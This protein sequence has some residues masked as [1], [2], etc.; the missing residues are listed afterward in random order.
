MFFARD[1]KLGRPVAIKVLLPD[2]AASLGSERFLREIE[3]AAKLTHPHIVGLHDSGEADGL[4]YYVM[5]FLD[6][7]SLRDR[8]DREK[9]LAIEDALQITRQVAD[10]LG[11]AHSMGIVHRDI[12][13]ENILFKAGHAVVSDFGIARAVAEAG[14]VSLTE[15][16]LAIGTPAYMSPEQ[17]SGEREPDSRTDIYALAC[18][19][20][21]MLAGE[22]PY[23]GPTAQA[24]LA[25]KSVGMVP[26]LRAVRETVPR[27]IELSIVRALAKAPADRF[28]TA[29]K[30]IEALEAFPP[31]EDG[32][33]VSRLPVDAA[34]VKRQEI[35]DQHT[36]L[37]V[38]N[39]GPALTLSRR[40]RVVGGRA[41]P[42]VAVAG[43][44]A[45]AVGGWLGSRVAPAGAEGTLI[46]VLP[47]E[48]IG[49]NEQALLADGMSDEL[50]TRLGRLPGISV[51]SRQSARQ[52]RDSPLSTQEIGRALGATHLLLGSIRWGDLEQSASIRVLP[53]LVD[54]FTD[55]EVWSEQFDMDVRNV[56][57]VQSAIAEA[58]A[59]ELGLVL[60]EAERATLSDRP[61]DDGEAYD[62]YLRGR[63]YEARGFQEADLRAALRMY[64][65]ATDLDPEFALA[66]ARMGTVHLAMF[67]EFYDR[68]D[69][70]LSQARDAID[71]AL[72]LEPSL[73][74]ARVALGR[75]Y[76]DGSG[77]LDAAERQF[78]SLGAAALEDAEVQYGLA[79]LHRRRGELDSAIVRFRRAIALDPRSPV[80]LFSLALTHLV[81]HDWPEAE[82]V[83]DRALRL[84]P[85][86]FAAQ[87]FKSVL[88][89]SWR[90]DAQAARQVLRDAAEVDGLANLVE[91]L[92]YA[93]G[94]GV[95]RFLG[96]EF[97]RALDGLSLVSSNADSSSYYL[98]KAEL[99]GR[100]GMPG[101]RL[102]YYDSARVVLEGLIAAAP[103]E[104]LYHAGL[105]I[106]YAGVGRSEDAIE[107]GRRAQELQPVAE[108]V[109]DGTDYLWLMAEILVMTGQYETA[110][111][112]IE[113][114]LEYPGI[115]SKPWIRAEAIWDPLRELPRFRALVAS[116]DP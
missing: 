45:L 22:P 90:G 103:T 65:Q 80:Q 95:F 18:V 1:L 60:G 6:G 91:R 67:R 40:I 49:R 114:A 110:V 86:L 77:D 10:A 52:F 88:Y 57:E 41:W 2:L 9:Q 12:K 102:A 13:P 63:G 93:G 29:A 83:F 19:L 62:A 75:Y 64:E 82:V 116:N 23:T 47:F 61:S 76:Q 34:A 89:M 16:G 72:R 44:A 73:P 5:P 107:H 26:L 53:T 11:Y 109:W 111:D 51:I 38:S 68:T 81:N 25:R 15:T 55:R 43:V 7:E 35:S 87:L 37:L 27:E 14:G 115:M 17:A 21:E 32:S 100:A 112:E 36:E 74:E 4:L 96:D 106:A 85:D 98:A 108:D 30:F 50:S 46:A 31:R 42:W 54:V 59:F 20:Y 84:A 101:R 66:Y 24:I 99:Y 94:W 56:I 78:L 92:V 33:D 105:G 69:A 79:G 28:R 8:L 71:E 58:V 104:A 39:D 48:S 113:N 70:R 97:D 3:I